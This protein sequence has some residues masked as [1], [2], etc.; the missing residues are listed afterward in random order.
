M[1]ISTAAGEEAAVFEEAAFEEEAD[2]QEFAELGEGP[3]A[4]YGAEEGRDPST[5]APPLPPRETEPW[6]GWAVLPVLALLLLP[7]GVRIR[8]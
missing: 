5:E 2:F 4:A 7:W 8:R 3:G 1:V 6:L